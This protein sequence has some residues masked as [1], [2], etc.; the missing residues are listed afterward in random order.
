MSLPDYL[1]GCDLD[2][3]E[4]CAADEREDRAQRNYKHRACGLLAQLQDTPN[5]NLAGRPRSSGGALRALQ[6]CP[7]THHPVGEHYNPYPQNQAGK[8]V[9][10]GFG[11]FV[12]YSEL[13]AINAGRWTFHP[14]PGG[15]T[16]AV[17]H[18]SCGDP[19]SFAWHVAQRPSAYSYVRHGNTLVPNYLGP[20][21][22]EL[23]D[24]A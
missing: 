1:Q 17:A 16:V 2:R 8:T 10:T 5:L 23:L 4:G 12:D 15:I 9:S 20:A 7:M 22:R 18:G 11:R 13:A 19:R 21:D 3:T 6:S 14:T 24:S